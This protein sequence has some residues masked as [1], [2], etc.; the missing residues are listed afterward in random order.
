MMPNI[1]RI[2]RMVG[3]LACRLRSLR[4][5]LG[6]AWQRKNGYPSGDGEDE[7]FELGDKKAGGFYGVGGEGWNGS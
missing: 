7:L 4:Q 2:L 6:K 1:N 3:R 5:R